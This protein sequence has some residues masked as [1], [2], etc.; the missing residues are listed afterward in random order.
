MFKSVDHVMSFA[1]NR[2]NIPV[3][4]GSSISSMMGGGGLGYGELSQAEKRDQAVSIIYIANSVLD[5]NEKAWV[6]AKYN[7]ALVGSYNSAVEESLV[8]AVI[9]S[10][11][12]GMHGRRNYSKLVINYFCANKIGVHAIRK[13]LSC[14]LADVPKYRSEVCQLLDSIWHRLEGKLEYE[15]SKRGLILHNAIDK[16]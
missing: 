11:P 8:R 15:F 10:L 6:L 9:G 7:S 3:V 12:T 16:N 2:A 1:F 14:G 13:D 4:K 5:E